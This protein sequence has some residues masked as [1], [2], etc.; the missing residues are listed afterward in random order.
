[1]GTSSFIGAPNPDKSTAIGVDLSPHMAVISHCSDTEPVF[2]GN[3]H[4]DKEIL[5]ARGG[6]LVFVPAPQPTSLQHIAA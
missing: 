6:V 2:V 4:A 3:R 1:M 5:W